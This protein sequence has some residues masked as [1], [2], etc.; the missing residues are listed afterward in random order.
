M[1][2]LF[3]RTQAIL[4]NPK[5]TFKTIMGETT[6]IREI[7]TSYLVPLAAIPAAAMLIGPVLYG[8]RFTTG[9]VVSAILYYVLTLLMI[10]IAGKVVDVLAP[11]F[12][13]PR[14]GL[15]A[16]RVAA[17]SWTPALV[18]G[19]LGII[20]TLA[21]LALLAGLYGIY[22]L[23]LGLLILMACPPE[24][25]VGY[26]VVCVLVM[27]VLFA[28]MGAVVHRAAW[29]FR[30]SYY[31]SFGSRE[32][33]PAKIIE[34]NLARQ[35]IEAKVD[36]AGGRV[37]VQTKEGDSALTTGE[38]VRI[39]DTFPKD[40]YVYA[41][42]KVRMGMTT[43]N[44]WNLVM[45]TKDPVDK[46]LKAF[47]SKMADSGWEG[48]MDVGAEGFQMVTY[49]KGTRTAT[50]TITGSRGMTQISLAVGKGT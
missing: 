5:P 3:E 1:S 13:A 18:A 4:L 41:G 48:Q 46:V 25:A 14:N 43:G 15:N 6:T 26:T 22:L 27:I 16:F 50:L 42:A 39:P 28:V 12:G 49:K 21:P 34:A 29:G 47:K 33:A 37:S 40:I 36:L 8:W 24:K 32:P 23:Y 45:E 31:G 20:P 2:S 10:F 44:G 35:G 11:N 38:D 9:L 17:Y 19:I 30:P 7:Y